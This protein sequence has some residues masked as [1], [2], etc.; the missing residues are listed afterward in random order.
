MSWSARF[1]S[2]VRSR[3]SAR[4]MSALPWALSSGN[5]S[6]MRS[7]SGRERVSARATSTQRAARWLARA[8]A[9][10]TPARSAIASSE[11]SVS[12]RSV[13]ERRLSRRV[14]SVAEL[15]FAG[16]GERWRS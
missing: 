12:G 14:S 6:S 11:A 15:I 4:L 7:I 1:G 8:R 5:C 16:L 13:A 9:A 2:G 10:C 3:A